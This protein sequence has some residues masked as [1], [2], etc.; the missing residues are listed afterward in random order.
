M[1][2]TEHPDIAPGGSPT[3]GDGV[4]APAHDQPDGR[5]VPG[6]F[7][8]LVLV[9]L[10]LIAAIGGYFLNE[11]THRPA[12]KRAVT[13]SAQ[14]PTAPAVEDTASLSP[15]VR[16]E[17][18]RKAG[19]L[20]LALGEYENALEADPHDVAALYGRGITLLDLGHTARAEDA[21][22]SVFAEE[23]GHVLTAETLGRY[24]ADRQQYWSLVKAVR[25]A[26]S[27][28]PTEARLQYLMGFAYERLG[29]LEWA[30]ARYR[31][32]LDAVPDMAEAAEGLERLGMSR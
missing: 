4:R 8:A 16:A 27:A 30:G 23:P 14:K 25:P 29:Y 11:I 15:L 17:T 2:D 13:P 19:Q 3:S 12:Q 28:H 26:V 22:W 18:L 21:L 5:V 9:G 24:Y 1:P 32:A 31:L 10:L 7:A 20:D 6:W